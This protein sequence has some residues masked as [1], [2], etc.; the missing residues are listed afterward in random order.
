MTHLVDRP[1]MEKIFMT[2]RRSHH[3]IVVHGPNKRTALHI[4]DLIELHIGKSNCHLCQD[5]VMLRKVQKQS[6]GTVDC[7]VLLATD[8]QELDDFVAA[9]DELKDLAIIL[10]LPDNAP[11]TIARAQRLKPRYLL[12]HQIDH[13]EMLAVIRTILNRHMP[14]D[15]CLI[16]QGVRGLPVP[17]QRLEK[18]MT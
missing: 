16:S 9:A 3:I 17:G 11:A 13:E 8:H 14:D 2:T 10:M 7:A 1:K 12:H 15:V 18:T 5:M 4:A 6:P